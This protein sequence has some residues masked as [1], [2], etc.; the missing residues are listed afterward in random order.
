MV[1][2]IFMFRFQ[3][4]LQITVVDGQI[5]T[6]NLSAQGSGTTIVT[7]PHL[8][9]KMDLGPLLSSRT[10]EKTIRF[11]NK[12]RRPQQIYW[13]TEGFSASSR[14]QKRNTSYNKD[15]MKFK[16]SE[17]SLTFSSTL[18]QWMIQV[19]EKQNQ[20]QRINRSSNYREVFIFRAKSL[21]LGCVIF[22]IN[23]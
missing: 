17:I 23:S 19:S 6:L 13:S 4:K 21:K 5:L 12:G 2:F 8:G 1:V 7:E 15:D 18:Y 20:K 11:V 3:D 22:T 14:A 16:V 9:P 10:L